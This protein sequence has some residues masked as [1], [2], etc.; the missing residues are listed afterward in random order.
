VLI[1]EEVIG[2]FRRTPGTVRWWRPRSG[3]LAF[4]VADP[5]DHVAATVTR[6]MVGFAA[7]PARPPLFRHVAAPREKSAVM[8]F[9]D[10][11]RLVYFNGL[12][13][14]W[15]PAPTRSST[16]DPSLTGPSLRPAMSGELAIAPTVTP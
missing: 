5:A 9:K 4:V 10:A 13:G 12:T 14:R 8:S 16:Y 3:F 7:A 1:K 2:R 11:G 6:Y 15:M